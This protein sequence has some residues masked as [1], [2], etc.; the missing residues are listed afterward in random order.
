MTVKLIQ[1]PIEDVIKRFP[2]NQ[3]VVSTL[4]ITPGK[5]SYSDVVINAIPYVY[6]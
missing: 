1:H 4:P 6:I 2:E 5:E 3:T